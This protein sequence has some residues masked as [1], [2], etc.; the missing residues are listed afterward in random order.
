MRQFTKGICAWALSLVLTF[1]PAAAD[2]ADNLRAEL[3][4]ILEASAV[5]G[6]G[7]VVVE[8]GAPAVEMYWGMADI[9]SGRAVDPETIFR[10][11][12]IS[13]N[14]TSLLA[15][16]LIEADRLDANALVADLAPQIEI[17]NR[18]QERAP[19]RVI[20]LLEHTA[21]LPGSTYRE[22]A[23]NA[24]DAA[25]QDYLDAIGR[26]RTRWPPGTLYSYSN[27]GHT[28]LARVLEV[29]TGRSFDDLAREE[30]FDPLGMQS[31][32]FLTYGDRP[33]RISNSYSLNGQAQPS[34]EMLIRPSGALSAVPADLAKLVALYARGPTNDAHAFVSPAALARMRGS[35][36]SAIADA[37][38]GDGAY[39][40]GTFPFIVDGRTYHGHWG[41]TE[42]FRAILG[43]LPGTEKGFV[44]M[45]NVV[46]ERAAS[47]LRAAIGAYLH[48]EMPAPPVLDL[49]PFD[50]AAFEDKAGAYVLAT[51]SQPLRA[52]LFKALDQRR[53]S[54]S[55]TG[56]VVTGQGPIAP[57]ETT[58]RPA[59]GGGFA[60]ENVP[61][62]TAAFFETDGKT[63]WIDRDAYVKVSGLEAMFRSAII[64]AATLVSIAA[65]LHSV[66]W[67]SMGLIGRGPSQQGLW[68]RSALLVSGLGFLI[69]MALFVNYALL[70]DWSKLSLVG[71]PSVISISMAG[72]SLAGVIGGLVAVAMTARKAVTEPS[73]FLIYAVPS[74]LTLAV[75]AVFWIGVGWFPLITWSW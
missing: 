34:W 67:G 10:A 38:A 69:T 1:L 15:L 40:F 30:I 37:G 51:H 36:A 23:E 48:R 46:D 63:Y 47:A 14:V 13:K 28:V 35:E 59:Q 44:I 64:P 39:G 25:P 70:G 65:L 42:G 68:V 27:A 60:A 45:L 43:Y 41:K 50:P 12:S 17:E 52:W 4:T 66:V 11:G 73:L 33:E 26:L 24:I 7:I 29:V 53:I 32:S 22:Y 21:G 8:D 71:K 18:W 75:F 54:V 55:E 31:A 62:A 3:V 2:A 19:V 58:F 49:R 6:A 61:V 5:K 56:L 72:A 74:S 20:H 16:R 9:E 57:P